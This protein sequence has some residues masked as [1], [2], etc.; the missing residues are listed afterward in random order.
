MS[1]YRNGFTTLE[2]ILVVVIVAV[3][4]AGAIPAMTGSMRKARVNEAR[5][6]LESIRTQLRL[7]RNVSGRYDLKPD[8]A[9]V[10][11]GPVAGNVPGFR[12][13]DLTGSNFLD[14]DY[15]IS[16]ISPATFT[17]TAQG[18]SA[19]VAG[20]TLTINQAGDITESGY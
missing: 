10:V 14:S 18:S 3:M 6:V 15:T 19:K 11:S 13:G 8:N 16:A 2:L 7:I 9:P 1:G 12:A 20:I 5:A 17:A 4:A